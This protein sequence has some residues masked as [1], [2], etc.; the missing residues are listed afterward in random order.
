MVSKG[1]ISNRRVTQGG[2]RHSSLERDKGQRMSLLA[3]QLLPTLVCGATSQASAAM[4]IR[5]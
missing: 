4:R 2:G 3:H 5:R 1:T